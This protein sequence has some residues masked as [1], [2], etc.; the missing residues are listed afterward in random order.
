MMSGQT[1][2]ALAQAMLS[3]L[4]D[5]LTAAKKALERAQARQS[6]EAN[7]TRRKHEFKIGESVM[8][9]TENMN[10]Q[11]RARKLV[12]KY[13]GPHKIIA[14]PTANTYRLELPPELARIHPVFNSSLLK[15]YKEDNV[16]FLDRPRIN[17]PPPIIEQDDKY[18]LEEI[19]SYRPK[20]GGEYLVKWKGYADSESSWR[21]VKEVNAPLLEKRYWKNNPIPGT[22]TVRILL[23]GKTVRATPAVPTTTTEP[24]KKTTVPSSSAAKVPTT[25]TPAVAPRR[26]QRLTQKKG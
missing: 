22:K 3:K 20:N 8:V 18:E 19:L 14:H 15:P 21:S 26:S 16:R 24:E 5:N 10:V 13:A 25:I 12:A 4:R 23:D 1:D 9:S 17:R 2:N 11:E 7:K 6:R